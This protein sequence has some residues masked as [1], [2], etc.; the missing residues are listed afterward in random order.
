MTDL[1]EKWKKGELPEGHYYI[2]TRSETNID[3]AL[4]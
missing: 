1:T 2:K 3:E 4:Q